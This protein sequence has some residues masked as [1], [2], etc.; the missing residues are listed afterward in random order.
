M[1]VK[2][3]GESSKGQNDQDWTGAKCPGGKLSKW[4]NVLLPYFR[5]ILGHTP[6]PFWS[7]MSCHLCFLPGDSYPP[8]CT[9]TTWTSVKPR[10]LQAS[11]VFFHWV[12][13]PCMLCCPIL[14]LTSS[15]VTLSFQEM[16]KMLLCHLLLYCFFGPW[17]CLII[18]LSWVE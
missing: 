16:P 12:C 15:F 3:H 2:C 9:R 5:L 8:V 17:A 7:V 14:T 10:N 1:L 11:G 6:M 13:H 4:R 18:K